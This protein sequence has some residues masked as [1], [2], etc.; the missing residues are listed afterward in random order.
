MGIWHLTKNFNLHYTHQKSNRQT[1]FLY[2]GKQNNCQTIISQKFCLTPIWLV[3]DAICVVKFSGS[4]F[5]ATGLG[6]EGAGGAS[7]PQKL[8]IWWKSVEIW[9]GMC[10]ILRKLVVRVLILQKWD[11]KQKYRRNESADVFFHFFG[12]H[13]VYLLLVHLVRGNLGK[14]GAWSALIWK[15]A[16]NAVVFPVNSISLGFF[17]GKF[18]KIW[19]KILRNHQK[20]ACSFTCVYGISASNKV[21]LTLVERRLCSLHFPYSQTFWGTKW[22][23]K[24]VFKMRAANVKHSN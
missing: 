5:M 13:F 7:S 22:V 4:A 17:S 19:A 8:L 12:G 9:A 10:E 2:S 1:L 16:T 15:N 24:D 14:N 20:F 21:R 23:R 3:C 18:G 6:G 11:P